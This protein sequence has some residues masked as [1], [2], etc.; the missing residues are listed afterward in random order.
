MDTVANVCVIIITIFII[1]LSIM[2]IIALKDV[3]KMRIKS[4]RFLDKM[5]HEINPI[6]SG[7]AQITEDI[8]QITYAARSQIEKVDSTADLINKNVNSIVEKWIK[9]VNSLHDA[10]AEPVGDIAVFLK[11]FSRGM[12]FFFGNGRDIKNSG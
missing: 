3:R 12:R 10:I 11:G 7:I 8:R 1:S 5:E 4:E 9:T 2:L 6:I